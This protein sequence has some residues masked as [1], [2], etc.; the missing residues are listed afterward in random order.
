MLRSPKWE[1]SLIDQFLW[2]TAAT[3]VATLQGDGQEALLLWDDSVLEKPESTKAEGLGFVRSSKA[4]RLKRI[5]PGFYTPPGGPP[6]FVPGL[7]WLALLV[8]GLTGAPTVAL[9]RWWSNRSSGQVS[10]EDPWELRRQLLTQCAT[11]WGRQVLHV[12]DRAYAGSGWLG[13]ALAQGVRFVVRW[14]KGW[15]LQPPTSLSRLLQAPADAARPAWQFTRGLRS[16]DEQQL[17]DPRRNQWFR[18][19]VLAVC[20]M[21]PQHPT[22]LWL[23]VARSASGKSR[24]EPWYLL[25]NE[26]IETEADAWRIV[27]AYARRWQIE[28]CFRYCKSELALESP[29]LWTWERRIKLLLLV[30]LAYAFL[31]SLLNERYEPLRKWLLRFFC[32]RTGKRGQETPAP[33]YRLRSALSRLWLSFPRPPPTYGRNPG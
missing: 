25:T 31:L 2:G 16:W 18:V 6:V 27:R 32:H 26:P 3:R 24:R 1:A 30:T 12:W 17:W 20:V 10:A 11:V 5:K 28:M 7:H 15:K 19:G 33:L 4:V 23:V 22:P 29:R 14:P 13:E 8:V 21:H 9:M